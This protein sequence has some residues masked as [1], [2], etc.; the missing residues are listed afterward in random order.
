MDTV[1]TNTTIIYNKQNLS[2][3]IATAI[4]MSE[5]HG[6]DVVDVS[7]LVNTDSDSF[8][9][10]G[11]DPKKHIDHFMFSTRHKEHI[12]IT[13]E[14]RSVSVMEI[15]SPFNRKP[16]LEVGEDHGDHM[17]VKP[18]LIDLVCKRFGLDNEDYKKLDFHTARF[19]ERKTEIE[20]LAF[21]YANL[22]EAAKCIAKNNNF[23]MKN[24]TAADVHQ[25][26]LDIKAVKSN[27]TSNYQ[28]ATVQD[29]NT[30]KNAIHTSISD[31]SIHLVLRLTRL[32]HRNFL[33]MSM[34]MSGAI[35][36]TNMRDIKFDIT[37]GRPLILN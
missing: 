8:I 10:V 32:V 35:A 37:M 18:T 4:L 30:V 33:N 15:L 19:Y 16:A 20:Y 6:V 7:Q 22:L 9:W 29:G 36:Y 25:Y 24:T 12:V 23:S 34:G 3:V 26:L 14:E 11:V 5:L 31:S 13:E 27:F 1:F 2:A 17:A 21:V 28:Q